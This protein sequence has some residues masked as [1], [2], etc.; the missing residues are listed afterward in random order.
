M[1]FPYKQP[2][3][4]DGATGT[5]LQKAGMS[6]GECTEKWAL[7]NP[8]AVIAIQRAY[9][10]AGSDAV[11][12]PTFGANRPLLDR[13]KIDMSVGDICRELVQISREAVQGKALVIG[14][15]APCGLQMEPFGATKYDEMVEVFTETAEAL[16]LAGVDFFGI[17]SQ[18]Y[19]EETKASVVAVRRVSNKPLIVTF[20]CGDTGRSLWGEDLSE[21]VTEL[22]PLGIDAYGI[23]C[24]G[25]LNLLE[26]LVR[27]IRAKTKLPII[28][29][30]NAGL[31][32]IKDGK[33][34]YNMTPQELSAHIP[35][36]QSA[37]AGIFGGCCGT[38]P[39]HIRAIKEAL[40]Q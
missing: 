33:A 37:G 35:A 19:L 15:I 2:F 28:V 4:M 8:E 32:V 7:E 22:E 20:A 3:I 25:D 18:I 29:K 27:E 10:E 38:E 26:R 36:L 6:L 1:A 16:E 12:A 13:H 23:N 31:P 17:E 5:M 34:H 21:S 11:Y 9:V 24:C 40:I 39:E 14:D 30:P